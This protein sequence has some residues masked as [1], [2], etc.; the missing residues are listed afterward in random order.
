MCTACNKTIKCCK[1]NLLE[2]SRTVKHLEN[3]KLNRTIQNVEDNVTELKLSHKDKVTR[4]E[5]KLAAYF[6]EHNIS[7]CSV[8]HLIDIE[9]Y[10]R[11]F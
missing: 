5:I 2:H 10:L 7:F 4:A 8:D 9:G 11:Q 1:T 3:E 6:A